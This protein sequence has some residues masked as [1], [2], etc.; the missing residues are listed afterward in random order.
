MV[1][2]KPKFSIIPGITSWNK[3]KW[4]DDEDVTG[5]I[6]ACGLLENV[7]RKNKINTQQMYQELH[8]KVNKGELEPKEMSKFSTVQNWITRTASV[9]KQ[10]LTSEWSK[11]QET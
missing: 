11:R 8:E 7:D 2:D 3:W 6:C 4:P 1:K 9:I 5:F 10:K